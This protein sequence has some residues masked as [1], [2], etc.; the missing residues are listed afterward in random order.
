MIS[1]KEIQEAIKEHKAK[2]PHYQ[3]LYDYYQS[4][5]VIKNRVLPD[6][7]KPNNKIATSYCHSVIET[8]VGY[9]ASRPVT[10]ISKTNDEE[11]LNK[12]HSI[13]FENDSE[14][15][16]AEHVKFFSIFGLTYELTYVD[17]QGNFRFSYY[18]PLDMYVKKDR[19]GNILYGL[20][21]WE[22]KKD[23]KTITDVELFDSQGTHYLQS[24]DGENFVKY[25]E[26][27][28]H[29]FN[30]TPIT[31]F[32]NNEE[33]VGD[34]EKQIPLVDAIDKMLS[35]SSNE[36]EAFA[37]AYLVLNG[38]EGTSKE[39]ILKLKQDGVL[40]LDKEG[41]AEWLIKDS[42][43]TFQQNFFDTL[44]RL[45]H[46]QTGTPKMTSEEFSSNLSGAA[47][48]N[49]LF[50]LESKSAVKERKMQKA[51]RKRLRFITKFI[52]YME[53]ASYNTNDIRF[54]FSRNIHQDSALITDQIV[55]LL[56]VVDNETLLSWHPNISEPAQ[57]IQK[58]K[59][60]EDSMNLDNVGE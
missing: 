34:F 42:E 23:D 21:Y 43:N 17:T 54:N 39:D 3:K 18:T 26:S 36:L 47:I 12:I 46:D 33:E 2:L 28:I 10:Y 44:D 30:E 56:G 35:D 4:N 48:R 27:K 14:D 55:K 22:Y 8:V 49:K 58:V 16:D 20:R 15:C 19:K 38:Y 5:S 41:K 53:N 37:N 45:I 52:N 25:Q 50:A 51:L 6:P 13:L 11:Y 32:M 60:Q 31:I 1:N 29:I 57:V 9:F 7:D 59:E 24:Q 40:L